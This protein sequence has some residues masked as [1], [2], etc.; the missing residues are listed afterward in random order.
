MICV[1][2]LYTTNSKGIPGITPY[3]Y[4][5][6]ITIYR[7]NTTNGIHACNLYVLQYAV[8]GYI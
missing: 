4:I 8:I 3:I 5:Y 1:Y 7:G 6:I 2:N